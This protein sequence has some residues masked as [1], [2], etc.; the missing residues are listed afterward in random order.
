MPVSLHISSHRERAVYPDREL[1]FWDTIPAIDVADENNDQLKAS[2]LKTHFELVVQVTQIWRAKSALLE[3][4]EPIT[5]LLEH[6]G[7]NVESLRPFK[8]TKVGHCS[9]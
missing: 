5:G 2:L 7:L 6:F 8:T 9:H 3:I 1:R 4:I